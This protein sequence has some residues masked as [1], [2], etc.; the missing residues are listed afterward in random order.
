MRDTAITA[1]IYSACACASLLLTRFDG[2]VAIVWLAGAVLFAKL[3]ATPRRRWGMIMLACLVTGLLASQLFGIRGAAALPLP[4]ICVAEACAAA[5][6]L[7]R[8]HPRF[9]RFQ[10]VPEVASFLVVAGIIV[11]AL[12]AVVAAWSVHEGRGIPYWFAFRD[13]YAGHALGLIAFAPPLLLTHR[14]ETRQWIAHAGRSRV[15]EASLLLGL[16]ALATFVTFAQ[17]DIPLVILPFMPMIAATLRLGRFGAVASIMIL[18][19]IALPFSWAG[20]GPTALLQVSMAVR[21]QVLQFYFASIV[22]ILLP[23]AAELRAR[24]RLLDRMRAAEALHRLVL[25]RTSDIVLRL[26]LD[27]T[28]RYA[29]P[30]AQR[31][32]GYPPEELTGKVMFHLV[33]PEDL[34]AVLDARRRALASPDATAIVEYRVICKDGSPVWME[35]HM[36]A[37]V[38]EQGDAVGTVSIVR[39]VT[40][41]RKLIEDLTRQATTDPLTGAYNRRAFDGALDAILTSAPASEV[42]GYIAVFDLDHFK[43]VNDGYGHAA[44][45][46]VLQRFAGVLK[47]SVREG[48]LV[49]RLGGE[50]FAVFLR[51][52]APG[53]ARLVCERIRKRQEKAESLNAG[54][55]VIRVTVSVGISPLVAGQTVEETVKT[56]DAALYRAKNAG[57]NRSEEAA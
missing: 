13:W 12:T 19:L 42:L 27:G 53:Q 26:G 10:S 7:K 14:G 16:V 55:Q 50:E 18:L 23:L 28:L 56:A 24:R 37:T 2:G 15:G 54:G 22:L 52:M 57:R 33:S 41:R 31:V 44:G 48:D 3:C 51:A 36:R 46:T 5:W 8:V 29:S 43:D 38:D 20:R 17:N 11:P 35:S 40:G 34:P 21:L 4:F 30:S 49:A 1:I 47:A 9:G 25:D 45:D 39:E 32:W 6:L